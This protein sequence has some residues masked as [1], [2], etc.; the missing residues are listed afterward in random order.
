MYFS[1]WICGLKTLTEPIVSP[2]IINNNSLFLNFNYTDTLEKTYNICSE[3]ILYIHGKA[4]NGDRLIIGHN[5]NS[6]FAIKKNHCFHH[7]KKLIYIMMRL[8]LLI[9]GNK[10]QIN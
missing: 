1:D 7:K 6:Y 9:L 5:D 10:R 2:M 4:L 3:N 8:P